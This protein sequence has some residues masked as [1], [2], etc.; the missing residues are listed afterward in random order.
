MGWFPLRLTV[1]GGVKLKLADCW[2]DNAQYCTPKRCS[3]RKQFT[4]DQHDAALSLCSI[5]A[6]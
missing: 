1:L 4:A 5:C 6:I 2:N 3:K